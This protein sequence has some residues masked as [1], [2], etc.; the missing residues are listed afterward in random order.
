MYPSVRGFLYVISF[1]F[2]IA[3]MLFITSFKY[4]NSFN[5]SPY[6]FNLPADVPS[7]HIPADN[8]M[9]IQGV[10]LGKKLFYDPLLSVDHTIACSSCH[11]QENGF[12]DNKKFSTGIGSQ[13]AERN[14]M[15]IVNMAWIDKYFWDGRAT[16]LEELVSFPL[17]NKKEMG[18]D[19]ETLKE[20]LSQSLEYRKMFYAAFG[21]DEITKKNIAKA[22]AQYVRTLTS[23]RSPADMQFPA[24][25]K[26]MKDN[27]TDQF[28]AMKTLFGFSDKSLKTLAL[29]EKCHN[30]LTYG[31]ME[32]KDNGLDTNN[33]NDPG[34]G[35]ITHKPED[36]G[37]FKAPSFRNLAFTAPYMHDGR[38]ATLDEVIEHYNTGIQPSPN[39]DPLLRNPDGSPL[40]LNLGKR[41]KK[42]ILYFLTSLMTDSTLLKI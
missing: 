34:L 29:C 40:R 26:I 32:M 3:V 22:I 36:V 12:A 18:K 13:H 1:A 35:A 15:P 4:T 14:T 17:T 11:H 5:P 27:N 6:S 24:V 19:I 25:Y 21:E 38:F 9:T 37:L 33:E 31:N 23:F 7:A 39:L 20:E 16:T 10:A 41:E 2:L 28:A 30:G 42:E 8:T